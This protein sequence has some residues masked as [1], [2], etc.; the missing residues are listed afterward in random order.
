M[1]DLVETAVMAEAAAWWDRD[2]EHV[3]GRAMTKEEAWEAGGINWPVELVPIEFPVGVE[4][5]WNLLVRGTDDKVLNCV[6]DYYTPLQNWDLLQYLSILVDKGDLE[7]E[8]AMSLKGGKVVTVCARNPEEVLIAGDA[9]VQYVTAANWHDGSRQA[10]IFFGEIR[11]ECWNTLNFGISAARNVFRFRHTGDLEGKMAE[12]R[13][14]LEVGFKYFDA[15]KELGEELA[16]VPMSKTEFQNFLLAAVPEPKP[17]KDKEEQAANER[18]VIRT[19][20]GLRMV[21]NDT[22]DLQNHRLNGEITAWGALQGTIAYN[23][24]HRGFRS[25]DTRFESA[26]LE[27]NEMTGRAVAFLTA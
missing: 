12:A 5:G 26:M 17:V 1:A 14:Q 2:G 3:Y 27:Q 8:S 16:L 9:H 25:P 23:D 7:I 21:C 10:H 19:R 4:S 18:A 15:I 24:H 13:Q 11:T 6:T 22:P 20:D